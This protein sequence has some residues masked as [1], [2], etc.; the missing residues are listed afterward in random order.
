EAEGRL[1]TVRGTRTEEIDIVNG[2]ALLAGRLNGERLE[3]A[4][5]GEWTADNAAQLD[6]LVS[7][8][9]PASNSIRAVDI[10]MSGIARLDT[11]GAWLLERILRG[12]SENGAQ[13]RVRRLPDR[14]RTLVG[15]VHSTEGAPPPAKDNSNL[16]CF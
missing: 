15:I 12:A 11:Y 10:D 9:T 13:A 2:E 6:R 16:I 7:A 3:L 4:A 1:R 5:G 14:F 8:A